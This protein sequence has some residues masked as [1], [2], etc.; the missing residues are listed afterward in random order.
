MIA[1]VGL[2][3][4]EAEYG[5]T[6]HNAGFVLLD[7]LFAVAEK[8]AV[9]KRQKQ[10]ESAAVT[11]GDTAV[12]LIKPRTF[13][14]ASGL[15]VAAAVRALDVPLDRVWVAYDDVTVPLGSFRIRPVGGSSGGHNG[16]E[17]IIDHLQTGEFGRVRIGIGPLPEK[18]DLAKYVLRRFRAGDQKRLSLVLD[19]LTDYMVAS[20]RHEKLKEETIHV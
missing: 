9:W 20:I 6:R 19:A 16:V 15:P 10:Y 5:T 3:N 13:M 4:P 18:V 7:R 17:S 2:G 8:D 1:I 12:T 11:I 14:N